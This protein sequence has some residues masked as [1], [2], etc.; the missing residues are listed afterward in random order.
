MNGANTPTAYPFW[1]YKQIGSLFKSSGR[2]PFRTAPAVV[3]LRPLKGFS[4]QKN[5]YFFN[6]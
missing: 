3:S 6:L 5:V 1:L 4:P 2:H